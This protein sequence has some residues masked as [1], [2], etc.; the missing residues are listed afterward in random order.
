MLNQTKKIVCPYCFYELRE[1][2]DVLFRASYS[3]DGDSDFSQR[4]DE[5]LNRYNIEFGK[6]PAGK[7]NAVIDPYSNNMVKQREKNS[8]SVIIT[9]VIDKNDRRSTDRLCKRCHNTLPVEIGFHDTTVISVAGISQAGKSAFMMSLTKK[10]IEGISGIS[11]VPQDL[12]THRGFKN[13]YDNGSLP[14][15]TP[16][17]KRQ[18]AYIYKFSSGNARAD[19]ILSFFDTSGEVFTSEQND[20]MTAD[21]IRHSDGILLLLDPF[22]VSK[23]RK[24][25]KELRNVENELN[26]PAE[27][28]TLVILK[29]VQDFI[30][31]SNKYRNNKITVPTA[32]ILT[33]SD[34]LENT[35][36]IS[37]DS[38]VFNDF[39]HEDKLDL[40]QCQLVHD[41]V[42]K[43]LN[44]YQSNIVD[45]IDRAFENYHFFAVSSLGKDFS[46]SNFTTEDVLSRR[47]AEPFLWLMYKMG[48]IEALEESKAEGETD[49]QVKNPQDTTESKEED[50]DVEEILAQ[51]RG[52]FL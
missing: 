7:M 48:Y 44:E 33:K 50:I 36:I 12:A 9:A 32:I 45:S 5:I 46:S 3:L 41:E 51:A 2:N 16:P 52:I 18:S 17:G 14:E 20:Y 21:H 40:K 31:A 42:K 35:G 22:R 43:L 25:I 26:F 39:E 4:E 49:T 37:E 11:F 8:G 38:S 23:L 1:P 29:L 15:A 28:Q 47:I 10:L 30:G 13:V 27:E 24:K 34:L 6:R 19:T